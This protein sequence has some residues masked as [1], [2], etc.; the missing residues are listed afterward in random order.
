MT[1]F[2]HILN[3]MRTARASR[4]HNVLVLF[5]GGI[6]F[7]AAVVLFV[8]RVWGVSMAVITGPTDAHSSGSSVTVDLSLECAAGSDEAELS[9]CSVD[10]CFVDTSDCV[11]K[12]SCSKQCSIT[13]SSGT[14]TTYTVRLTASDSKGME[15][16]A[17][18][19]ID[20][21][22]E[23]ETRKDILS[24]WGECD[25]TTGQQYR[26]V[27]LSY[28]SCST[29]QVTE[30]QGCQSKPVL[31][32]P[33]A[34]KN[35]QI[36]L[37]GDNFYP[38][39][40]ATN[41]LKNQ[42]YMEVSA[43]GSMLSII[44]P[45]NCAKPDDVKECSLTVNVPEV[46]AC[47]PAI[48]VSAVVKPKIYQQSGSGWDSGDNVPAVKVTSDSFSELESDYIAAPPRV[49][50]VS[51]LTHWDATPLDMSGDIPYLMISSPNY[52]VEDEITIRGRD[53]GWERLGG[54]VLIQGQEVARYLKWSDTEIIVTP[55]SVSS[56]WWSPACPRQNPSLGVVSTIS[57]DDKS[58][59]AV[60]CPSL[61]MCS[62]ACA[63]DSVSPLS[64]QSPL[65]ATDMDA[66]T[67][68][69]FTDPTNKQYLTDEEAVI[70][71]AGF[72][73]ARHKGEL[74][75]AGASSNDLRSTAYV[76]F[77]SDELGFL[78]A[79]SYI[80]WSDTEIR[81]L[82]PR[83][84]FEEVYGE[85]GKKFET[86]VSAG[87]WPLRVCTRYG[88]STNLTT[89]ASGFASADDE[90]DA[91]N[92]TAIVPPLGVEGEIVEI[93][94][95][96][97]CAENNCAL[98]LKS[99]RFG[100]WHLTDPPFDLTGVLARV[101]DVTPFMIRAEVPSSAISGGVIIERRDGV[102]SA[103]FEFTKAPFI[104]R[105][106]PREIQKR[107]RLS[108]Y[109]TGF[110]GAYH[111]TYLPPAAFTGIVPKIEMWSANG[112][113]FPDESR[114]SPDTYHLYDYVPFTFFLPN[115]RE[116][117]LNHPVTFIM[118]NWDGA[119]AIVDRRELL[120]KPPII[121]PSNVMSVKCL[122]TGAT[123]DF[124]NCSGNY[125]DYATHLKITFKTALASENSRAFA[126]GNVIDFASFGESDKDGN[127]A[128]AL[129]VN[130]LYNDVEK[131]FRKGFIP[132]NF[133]DPS[134]PKSD[135]GGVIVIE[136][137]AGGKGRF[138]LDAETSLSYE[139]GVGIDRYVICKDDPCAEKELLLPGE[140]PEGA[141]FFGRGFAHQD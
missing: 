121:T 140:K 72:L 1:L 123:F 101:F 47:I 129:F 102:A 4:I 34:Y 59:I 131:E 75:D 81:S 112:Y 10:G 3:K 20:V 109:G 8:I 48:A 58:D 97:L 56:G 106:S 141:V 76:E 24:P 35:R 54:R 29:S 12:K 41:P 135:K 23:C 44:S 92:I 45:P 103:P 36:T 68:K 67:I 18:H 132:I 139:E 90:D 111:T 127:T 46:P 104:T 55:P 82:P 116:A 37:F 114:T 57:A 49:A 28:P 99:A 65:P 32:K 43:G 100:V 63:V 91:P 125:D 64:L 126:G 89:A 21:D 118:S 128:V 110:Y 77:Y 136:R 73:D 39:Q 7:I 62:R 25:P 119:F 11:G 27:R 83:I 66:V 93:H 85:P 133:F 33:F 96:D 51:P 52:C 42:S 95:N 60:S 19:T 22:T 78:P 31:T 50:A 61:A 9:S 14:D 6:F 113:M 107:D 17:S 115:E 105:I 84:S 120:S 138:S 40:T 130:T 38:T 117:I 30:M 122:Q 134:D 98:P 108:F 16:S 71:G 137:V 15:G 70:T 53:F 2:Q 88:C 5:S 13:F 87:G 74:A 94:G 86:G 79:S 69:K 124:E 26:T 80:V